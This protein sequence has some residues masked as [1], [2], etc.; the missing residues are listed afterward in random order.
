MLCQGFK[1]VIRI[2]NK[3]F[4]REVRVTQVEWVACP[5]LAWDSLEEG[6]VV[7]K[8][9]LQITSVRSDVVLH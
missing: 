7:Y 4:S 2:R 1:P 9:S 5:A 6:K 8:L 3:V